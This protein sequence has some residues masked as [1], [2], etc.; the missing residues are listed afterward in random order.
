M[1][2]GCPQ[3]TTRDSQPEIRT[4]GIEKSFDGHHV[5]RGVDL[6]IRQGE[7]VAIV[8][9]SGAGKTVLLDHMVGLVRPDRG[10]VLVADHSRDGAPLVDLA[11]L[12]QR[13]LER[14]RTHWALVFQTNALYSGSVYDN[15][16][17]WLREHTDLSESQIRQRASESLEMV[18]FH[19][20]ARVM[21]KTRDQLSG[22]MAKRVA[23]ARA[24]AMDPAILFYDEPSTGLDPYS[25]G[26]IQELICAT[27]ARPRGDGKSQTTVIITHDKDLLRRLRP[28]VVMLHHGCVH[29]DGP[30]DRFERS[31]SEIIR[32]YFEMMPALQRAG[33]PV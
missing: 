13:A 6:E 28:R 27:H 9:G 15:I 30:Y 20:D 33:E 1:M 14:L 22:G 24:L 17:L 3:P 23:V 26:Q 2:Q 19:E 4:E 5:L 32:P 18:G 31:D 11:S 21:D 8:G 12:D 10:R 29:F 16:A 7:I 25:A